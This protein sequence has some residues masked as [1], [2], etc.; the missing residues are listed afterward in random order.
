MDEELY[1]VVELV[2]EFVDGAGLGLGGS[3]WKREGRLCFVAR[4]KGDVLQVAVGVGDMFARGETAV[5]AGDWEEIALFVAF[6][7]GC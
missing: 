5:E 2:G 1:E 3:I 7:C 6:S 4:G